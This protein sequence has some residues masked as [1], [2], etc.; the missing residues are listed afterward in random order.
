MW[1][2]GI[3]ERN[4][5]RRTLRKEE[6]KMRRYHIREYS[7]IWWMKTIAMAGFVVAFVGLMNSWEIGIL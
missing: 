7:P 2:I 5:L 3:V 4:A 6:H 1:I